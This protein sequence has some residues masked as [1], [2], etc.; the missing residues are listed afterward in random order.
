MNLYYVGLGSNLGDRLHL[1]RSALALLSAEPE[2]TVPR[3]SAVYETD[4]VGPFEQ[5]DF[6]NLVVEVATPLAP[7]ELLVRCLAIEIRLRR[8]RQE[9]W[10]PRTIDLDLLL[11]PRQPWSDP[12]L[13][14]PHPRLHLRAFML[15]PLAELAPDLPLEGSTVQALARRVDRSGLRPFATWTQFAQAPLPSL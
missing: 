6:L 8:V 4:P 14:L 11:S 5:P 15:V 3:G 12:S 7:P 10:G 1:L 2:I 9:R 13:Q